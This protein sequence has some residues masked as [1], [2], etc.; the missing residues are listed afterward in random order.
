MSKS[1]PAIVTIVFAV[2]IAT[3]NT[4]NIPILTAQT[5]T[6]LTSTDTSTTSADIQGLIES[7]AKSLGPLG[8]LA[9]YLYR[10]ETKTLPDK[11][12][13]LAK[14]QEEYQADI[15][16]AR[17]LFSTNLDKL[18]SQMQKQSDLILAVVQKCPGQQQ[19]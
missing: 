3:I 11:D 5:T 14:A 10:H 17:V 7:L 18:M 2:I 1:G 9:W 6:G 8:I 4:V 16:K 12:A 15:D 19:K 13:A